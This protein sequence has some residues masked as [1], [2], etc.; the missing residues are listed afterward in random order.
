M[1]DIDLDKYRNMDWIIAL[2][3]GAD[4]RLLLELCNNHKSLA[5]S[6][7][8]IYVHHHLQDVADDW[9]I[10]CKKQ[11]ESLNINFLV[12]HVKVSTKG[13]VEAN[14][15]E[16]RYKA[17]RKHVLQNSVLFTAHHADDLLET[18]LLSLIRGVGIEGLS[19]L[20]MEREFDKGL[21]VRPLLNFSRKDIEETC[22]ELNLSYVI[23]P[24]N[25][26]SHYDRNYLRNKVTPLLKERFP[27]ILQN[28]TRTVQNLQSDK[29]ILQKYLSSELSPMVSEISIPSLNG[30]VSTL[31]IKQ[32]ENHCKDDIS[33]KL[34]LVRFFLKKFYNLVLSKAQLIL[35]V[36]LFKVQNSSKPLLVQDGLRIAIYRDFLYVIKDFSKLSNVKVELLKNNN[37]TYSRN[38][39]I[40]GINLKVELVPESNGVVDNY[41]QI[42]VNS[43]L[44]SIELE[45]DFNPKT[46]LRLHP[47]KRVHSQVLKNLWKEYGIPLYLRVLYPIVLYKDRIIGCY[48]LFSEKKRVIVESYT[49][50]TTSKMNLIVTIF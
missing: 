32:L 26:D 42:E 11:C 20:P 21:L 2:S 28:T 37:G 18:V 29:K 9:A 17:L 4:S 14:A 45:L 50:V 27:Q 3:G 7:K 46:S 16:E 1:I 23:D 43:E 6:I 35:L 39:N 5:N 48:G 34:S 25:K 47:S 13:S 44:S 22:K 19:S 10:F 31:N 49:Q 38:L 15:R 33:I 36:D 12:E 8:A 40:N 41:I 30:K 24:T